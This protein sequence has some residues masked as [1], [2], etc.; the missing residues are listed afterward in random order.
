M[1]ILM[2][3]AAL[4]FAGGNSFCQCPDNH[5]LS[6]RLSYLRD[7]AAKYGLSNLAMLNELLGYEKA[8]RQCNHISD[9]IIGL[10]YH[11][12]AATYY[13]L[14]EYRYAERYAVMSATRFKT[15]AH[16]ETPKTLYLTKVYYL[17][18]VIYDSLGN[19][20]EHDRATDSLLM[21]S[22]KTIT[23]DVST[24]YS[25]YYRIQNLIAVG[26][27]QKA[28][29]YSDM[30]TR[31]AENAYRG[32]NA[33]DSFTNCLRFLLFKLETL[34]HQ[35]KIGDAEKLLSPDIIAFAEK[36][37]PNDLGELYYRKGLIMV[38][39]AQYRAAIYYFDKSI[40]ADGSLGRF[41]T[42]A[43]T[44]NNVGFFLYHIGEKN[45]R[46]A[47]ET[48]W[49]S[50]R[51]ARKAMINAENSDLLQIRSEFLNIY[52][53]LA[54]SYS[55][56][57]NF[58]SSFFYIRAA[59]NQIRPGIH[60]QELITVFKDEAI[61]NAMAVYTAYLLIYEGRAML[62]K[63]SLQK[64]K[65]D[66]YGVLNVFHVADQL[67][68]KLKMEQRDISSKL[69]WRNDFHELY[70]RAIEA[71]YLQENPSEAFYFIEKGKAVLLN[72]ELNQLTGISM[73]DILT[74]A[75]LKKHIADLERT[76]RSSTVS[77]E[78]I[79]DLENEKIKTKQV[80]EQIDQ[81][82]RERNPIYYQSFLDTASTTIDMVKRNLLKD[83]SALIELFEGDSAVYVMMVGQSQ[84]WLHRINKEDYDS[85]A[86][87]FATFIS[88]PSVRSDQFVEFV[89]TAIHLYSIIFL[90]KV[91]PAGR[92]IIS[93][94]GP[95]Y[96]FEALVNNGQVSKPSYFLQKHATSYT[97]SA[98][99]LLNQSVKDHAQTSPLFLG[100][101]PVNYSQISQLS[102][103]PESDQSLERIG[104]NFDHPE[105]LVGRAAT[106]IHFL[107]KFSTHRI[108]QLYTHSSDSSDRGEPVIHFADSSLYLSELIPEDK[109]ST[110]L[111]VLSACETGLGKLY[112][113]EGIFSFNRAFASIGIPS[114][115]INLSDVD[116]RSTYQLTELF[117][118]YLSKGMSTDSAL[119]QAKLDY[120]E[121]ASKEKSLP[122]YW[123]AT[124]LA[125]KSARL[126]N[127]EH[128]GWNW[129]L[130]PIGIALL[131]LVTW[132][133]ALTR[134]K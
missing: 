77:Q 84:T 68:L 128:S 124:V 36:Y 99:Y 130:I 94:D 97:Y 6:G 109:P 57:G 11:R 79:S 87:K 129:L 134:K 65:K 133:I 105:N 10:V 43:K 69:F 89:H 113:G 56:L 93:P 61:A 19:R 98:R 35:R 51:F 62:K 83:A 59:L 49:K 85:T 45:E 1:K 3:V 115:I 32:K 52:A 29:E 34:V 38:Y 76:I 96:P 67:L 117:Y 110:Q 25:L 24:L 7:S 81:V 31:L 86:A 95:Y 131:G 18:S 91:L 44:L 70:E 5:F 60:E 54:D 48:Y 66:L 14:K 116:N 101:A 16:A 50:L 125:G 58:N 90:D 9:S 122:Y 39:K 28:F 22:F 123:A 119:Q 104:E 88:A 103:L 92:I 73:E 21:I 120:L 15:L 8:L 64:L 71:S 78:G 106:K 72:D 30:A 102:S 112:R 12:I 20:K 26:D 118:K 17:L 23:A 41:L 107:R 75:K 53:N 121:H 47:I 40:H 100:F 27:Y 63:Y 127:P 37:S 74:E 33:I 55:N 46:K 2:I 82:I 13:R 114:A 108:V 126:M 111:I 132:L 42:C 80:L 4:F